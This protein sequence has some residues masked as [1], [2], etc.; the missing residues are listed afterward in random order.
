M[1]SGSQQPKLSSWKSDAIMEIYWNLEISWKLAVLAPWVIK[2]IL[3]GMTKLAGNHMKFGNQLEIN[4][5]S[6]GNQLKISCSSTMGHK[7]N[8]VRYY[9]ISWKSSEILEI[10]WKSAGK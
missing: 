2:A 8:V 1:P 7:S 9:E 5:K 10:S 4:W 3:L 6:V